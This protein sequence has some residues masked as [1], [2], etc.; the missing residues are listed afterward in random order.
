[1]C[2]RDRAE[3]GIVT[4]HEGK[5]FAINDVSDAYTD[6]ELAARY[7]KDTGIDALAASVGTVHGF[8]AVSYTHLDVYKRQQQISHKAVKSKLNQVEGN[9]S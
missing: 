1:M 9:G 4:G 3:I 7:V 5:T 6:P 2:I 8:Y